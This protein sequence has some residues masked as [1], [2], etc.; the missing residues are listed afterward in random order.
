MVVKFGVG[1]II[2]VMN[3][4]VFLYLKC[5]FLNLVRRVFDEIIEKDERLWMSMMIGYV[6][7]G[8]F[9]LGLELFEGMDEGM[10]LV[11]YNVLIF[12]YVYR[13]LY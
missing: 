1:S 4:L 3:V 11:V 10:K 2:F 8:F 6:K 7:N 13:G 12:G 9:D 5:D